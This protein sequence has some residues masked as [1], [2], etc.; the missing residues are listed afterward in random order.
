MKLELTPNKQ[1]FNWQRNNKR[2]Y[3]V[4]RFLLPR[5]ILHESK[6]G[7]LK[8]VNVVRFF[9]LFSFCHACIEK[10]FNINIKVVR[11]PTWEF[12]LTKLISRFFDQCRP[13]EIGFIE[14]RA[15]SELVLIC[16]L[17]RE[18][19]FFDVSIIIEKQKNLETVG[20]SLTDDYFLLK[21]KY[22]RKWA[23]ANTLKQNWID[24]PVRS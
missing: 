9:E 15:L 5:Q 16:I 12:T 17:I 11:A 7:W 19:K 4:C 24:S 18:R 1:L 10:E 13:G 20:L 3:K 21:R 22:V 23:N 6:V 14:Y 8:L 2:A